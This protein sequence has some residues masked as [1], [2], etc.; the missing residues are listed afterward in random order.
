[1]PRNSLFGGRP[2]RMTS[3]RGNYSPI[4]NVV[5]E[6][7]G[8]PA[9]IVMYGDIWQTVPTD[10]WT[11]EPI[12]GMHIALDEMTA[13]IDA[14]RDASEIVIRINSSGGNANAG[15][16]IHNQLRSFAGKKTV[17]VEGWAASAASVIM[18]AGD[19]IKVHPS[20]EVLIHNPAAFLCDYY[21]MNDL[22]AVMN[23][24][25]A[26]VRQLKAVYAEHTGKSDD[27]LQS[28]I[29]ASTWFVGQEII[30]AGFA[31]EMIEP[32][33]KIDPPT[34][35][36][37]GEA[38]VVAGVKHHLYNLANVPA[39]LTG[40]DKGRGA[41]EDRAKPTPKEV[42]V[43]ITNADEL[44]N[45][46][47]DY[48]AQLINA[49]T[50]TAVTDA[51][52]KAVEAERKRLSD[53]DAIAESIDPEL[54]NKAKYDEPMTAE[55]LSLMAIKSQ[56]VTSANVLDALDADRKMSGAG[57]VETGVAEPATEIDDDARETQAVIDAA[58]RLYKQTKT[59]P[60]EAGR[61]VE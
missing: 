3:V 57:A 50:E 27:E 49:A 32:A 5:P 18:C 29:D 43:T 16:T 40:G 19:V 36:D 13:R 54:V 33:Y 17:I 38:V 47:P 60:A 52:A 44:R 23:D 56:A 37:D 30:D 7:D 6:A 28:I 53:I 31:D 55:Q 4:F 51:T 41:I 21:T 34:T 10:W 24:Y 9:E 11:G 61:E 46:Y 58:V 2:A 35:V 15:V 25:Q 48:V 12:E 20:S 42:E 39:W 22:Q 8:K 45:A 26:C 14:L 1:M 59:N